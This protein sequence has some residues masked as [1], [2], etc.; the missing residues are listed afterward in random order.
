MNLNHPSADLAKARLMAWLTA[1]R[2]VLSQVAAGV[3][4]RL[5]GFQRNRFRVTGRA[6][7]PSSPALQASEA[8]P[9][10]G[11]EELPGAGNRAFWIGLS[12]V[13]LSLI[14]GFATYFILTGLTP[15][16]PRNSVV[17]NVLFINVVLILAMFAVLGY[18]AVGL[19]RAW[20]RKVAGARIHVRIVG[21]FTIIAAAPAI[22]LA[23]AATTT[24]SRSIDKIGRAHV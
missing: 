20:Q 24:F 13:I 7:L 22:L 9:G 21:L 12:V 8:I 1:A 6:G 3:R 5:L 18:Q 17:V 4:A 11:L 10:S 2:R 14:S 19:W 15:I 23:L 16:A